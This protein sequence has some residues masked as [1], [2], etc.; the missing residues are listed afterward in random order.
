MPTKKKVAAKPKKH[1]TLH[2]LKLS[3]WPQIKVG[4]AKAALTNFQEA[5][6]LLSQPFVWIKES[7]E[8]G[9][10]EIKTWD[11]EKGIVDVTVPW[12]GCLIGAIE[13]IDG[14]GELLAATIATQVLCGELQFDTDCVPDYDQR[15]DLKAKNYIFFG[16][17]HNPEV[18][19]KFNDNTATTL[20]D[21]KKFL[22][23]CMTQAERI[24]EFA[25]AK[26]GFKLS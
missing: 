4:V 6:T 16:G 25:R 19:E 7:Y 18:V 14:L 17:T 12:Q 8:E 11:P 10:E 26:K 13:K 5:L 15:E 2:A 9:N 20:A 24:V 1:Y 23:F 3:A 21:V 22:R